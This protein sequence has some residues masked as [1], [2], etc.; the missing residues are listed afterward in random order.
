[1]QHHSSGSIESLFGQVYKPVKFIFNSAA[2][3]PLTNDE[4]RNYFLT[5]EAKGYNTYAVPEYATDRVLPLLNEIGD[6]TDLVED[7]QGGVNYI[8]YTV[9]LNKILND[10]K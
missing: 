10:G 3:K 2:P 1:M 9:R 8:V 7:N 4:V 6:V 5:H